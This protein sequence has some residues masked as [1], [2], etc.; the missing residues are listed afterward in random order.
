MEVAGF[1]DIEIKSE[2]LGFYQSLDT[3]KKWDGTWFHPQENPLLDMSPEKM[4]ELKAEYRKLIEANLT[5]QGVWNE[6]IMFFVA[7]RK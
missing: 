7:G 1:Q 5:E 4:E 3:A 2:Q 6:V